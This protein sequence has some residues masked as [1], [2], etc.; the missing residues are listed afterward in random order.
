LQIA[1]ALK[2]A[3]ER[4][5][6]HRDLKPANIRFTANRDVKVLDFGLAKSCM[7]GRLPQIG[8]SRRASVDG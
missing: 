5:V 1:D 2:A 3:H 8:V 7:L 6:D 4:G